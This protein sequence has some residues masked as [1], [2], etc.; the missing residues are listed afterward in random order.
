MFVGATFDDI[1]EKVVSWSIAIFQ[2]AD[3]HHIGYIEITDWEDLLQQVWEKL[4]IPWPPSKYITKSL[5]F[6]DL[7]REE[8]LSEDEFVLF[9]NATIE[10][11]I[12][13]E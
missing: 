9:V 7:T 2:Q 5:S 13:E 10:Q 1:K 12:T 11:Y 3:E 4:D 6:M 8:R